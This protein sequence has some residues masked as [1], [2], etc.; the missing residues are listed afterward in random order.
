M[1]RRSKLLPIYTTQHMV[2]PIRPWVGPRGQGVQGENTPA[3][4][5]LSPG[6]ATAG[7]LRATSPEWHR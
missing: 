2:P 6:A 1:L 3:Q 4:A 7:A 5:A